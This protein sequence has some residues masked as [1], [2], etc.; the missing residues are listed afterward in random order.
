MTVTHRNEVRTGLLSFPDRPCCEVRRNSL[1]ALPDE[2]AARAVRH[3]LGYKIVLY[4]TRIDLLVE[5]VDININLIILRSIRGTL[6]ELG[7]RGHDHIRRAVNRRITGEQSRRAPPRE[8]R[9]QTFLEPR[10][11]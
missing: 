9:A 6:T 10:R 1:Q 11:R 3:S 2:L 5:G 8:C 7:E 4:F